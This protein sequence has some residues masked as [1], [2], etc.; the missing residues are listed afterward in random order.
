LREIFEFIEELAK[1][2]DI[3]VQEVVAWTVLEDLLGENLLERARAFMQP[4][5][6]V[7][8]HE[9]EEFWERVPAARREQGLLDGAAPT[10]IQEPLLTDGSLFRTWSLLGLVDSLG[11]TPLTGEQ[12]ESLR[13]V[14]L[15]EFLEHGLESNDEPNELGRRLDDLIGPLG[16]L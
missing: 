14:L 10:G 2:Q 12:R 5:T 9:V 13:N 4:S 3:H 16:S 6:M 7:M 8:S 11:K 1:N 15:D